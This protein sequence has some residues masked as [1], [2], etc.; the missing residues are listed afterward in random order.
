MGKIL[1]KFFSIHKNNAY[2][3]YRIFGIKIQIRNYKYMIKEM[4]EYTH[5]ERLK[6]R[7]KKQNI[8]LP[9]DT[10]LLSD[11]EVI[12]IALKD[13]RRRL[14]GKTYTLQETIFYKYLKHR[15]KTFFLNACREQT[16]G[17]QKLSESDAEKILSEFIKLEEIVNKEG[18][19]PSV[20]CISLNRN[21]FVVDGQRRACILLYK[22]GGNHK[23]T[24][25]REKQLS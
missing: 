14:F 13:I 12:Q 11:V 3:I 2:K 21:N 24:V 23:I 6:N 9:E 5:H 15:D 22:Y 1:N 4:Y 7:L 10:H 8:A 19:N 17:D 20:S 25:I 18:Y 16:V